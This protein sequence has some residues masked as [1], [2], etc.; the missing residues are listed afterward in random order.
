MVVMGPTVWPPRGVF[1]VALLGV[2]AGVQLSDLGLQAI[3]LSA[4]QR[5]FGVSDTMLGALQGLA[6]IL[7]GSALAI[8]VARFADRFSRKKVL[9]C[10][11]AASIAMMMLS[12]LAPSFPLFFIGRSAAS[13]T[14]FAMVPLVYSLIPDLAPE[15]HRVL[16]NLCFAALM[17]V[18]ASGGFYFA[19]DLLAI[20]AA[21][22]PAGMEPWRGA[23]L[24]LSVSS[25]PLLVLAGQS[26]D[27]PR[28]GR[29]LHSLNNDT[30]GY[31]LR[32]RWQTVALFVGAAGCLAFAVQAL[33]QL[34]A[35]AMERQFAA[36]PGAIGRMM[37]LIVFTS[38]L[39]CLPIAWWLDRT[40]AAR[41]GQ[42]ARPLIMGCCVALALVFFPWMTTA[43]SADQA[44]LIVLITFFATSTANA[45][46]PTI[47]QDLIP[48]QIRARGF[49]VWSF[50]V[51]I[52]GAGGPLLAGTLSEWIF[53][54]RL[55]NALLASAEP[56]LAVSCCCAVLSFA[57]ESRRSRNTI[58]SKCPQ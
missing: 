19:G 25:L 9:L 3:S 6:G 31:F 54:D 46:V 28:Y 13:I 50:V 23:F 2:V 32:Q 11:I 43:D 27:T 34:I 45:L 22:V 53:E 14:E 42:A 1:T 40:L 47:L 55:L 7:V 48:T 16:A 37:G 52:F 49:A 29:V 33:N 35:L 18:G 10:L 36:A 56:A 26:T 21:V 57:A 17:A 38:T 15:R 51:S 20:A 5:S 30:L 41:L 8:P 24:I 58:S 4:I 12:A 39:G 44:F